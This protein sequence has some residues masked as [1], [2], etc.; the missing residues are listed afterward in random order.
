RSHRIDE[1]RGS[2]MIEQDR[3]AGNG[4]EARSVAGPDGRWERDVL[5]K[6]LLGTLQERRRAR[7]WGIFFK[8]LGFAWLAAALL[9]IGGW[10]GSDGKVV[11]G[12]HTAL[13]DL[14]G[15]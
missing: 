9:V 2:A 11:A 8:L 12:R 3:T 5:E 6:L 1:S 4:S 13:V 14:D 10:F 15:V 7:R